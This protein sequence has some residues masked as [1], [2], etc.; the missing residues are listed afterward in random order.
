MHSGLG[1]ETEG[2]HQGGG[3][4]REMAGEAGKGGESKT[5]LQFHFSQR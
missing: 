3:G 1:A 4:L 5:G 2:E